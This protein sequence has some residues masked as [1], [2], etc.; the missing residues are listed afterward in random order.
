[1]AENNIP[2]PRKIV[3][4]FNFLDSLMGVMN[5]DKNKENKRYIHMVSK[6]DTFTSLYH[7]ETEK[8]DNF[9]KKITGFMKSI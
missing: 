7:D 1:M 2:T 5:Q 3:D 6:F 8:V 9:H 4:D